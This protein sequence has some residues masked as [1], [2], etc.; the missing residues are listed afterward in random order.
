MVLFV[1]VIQGGQGADRHACYVCS[2]RRAGGVTT[3]VD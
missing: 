3:L 1:L 2:V